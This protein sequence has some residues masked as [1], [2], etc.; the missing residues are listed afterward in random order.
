MEIWGYQKKA[1]EYKK[2]GK[3]IFGEVNSLTE[4]RRQSLQKLKF[5]LILLASLQSRL[6]FLATTNCS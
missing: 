1:A 4:Q 5:W 6:N 2:I 3:A